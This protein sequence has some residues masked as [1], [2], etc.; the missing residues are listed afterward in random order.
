[1]HPE[2]RIDGG[3]RADVQGE[4]IRVP[5]HVSPLT[6]TYAYPRGVGMDKDGVGQRGSE[7]CGRG[8]K[9]DESSR[10]D[11]LSF[12]EEERLQRQAVMLTPDFGV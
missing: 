4:V 11:F 3:A 12:L 10:C 5:A 8:V 7:R 2:A 6:P 1:M 9:K